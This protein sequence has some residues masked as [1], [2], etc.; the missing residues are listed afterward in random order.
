MSV[1]WPSRSLEVELPKRQR[2]LAPTAELAGPF[3]FAA[4]KAGGAL[5]RDNMFHRSFLPHAKG[6]SQRLSPRVG[7]GCCEAGVVAL[8]FGVESVFAFM[9]K[10]CRYNTTR[11][12]QTSASSTRPSRFECYA[13]SRLLADDVILTNGL[14]QLRITD[15]G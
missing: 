9:F 6:C 1:G 7:D 5:W 11:L 12:V 8:G 3:E 14:P 4:V 15:G 2:N 10:L 13:D